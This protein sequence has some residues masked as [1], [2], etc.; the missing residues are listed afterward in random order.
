MTDRTN[1][2][3]RF[4]LRLV[5]WPGESKNQV[6]R[7]QS[8]VHDIQRRFL[9]SFIHFQLRGPS[10]ATNTY[11]SG[12]FQPHPAAKPPW[13]LATSSSGSRAAGV[14]EPTRWSALCLSSSVA[15]VANHPATAHSSWAE[16][17]CRHGSWI[18]RLVLVG[19]LCG[20]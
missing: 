6:L 10:G 11:T 20:R 5:F 12:L 2:C 3:R 16:N 17:T 15:A 8:R 4:M 14:P 18:R 9:R 19:R 7:S 1:L 13:F